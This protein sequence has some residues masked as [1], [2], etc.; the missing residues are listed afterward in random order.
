MQFSGQPV[1]RLPQSVRATAV[2]LRSFW[3]GLFG[4]RVA[5]LVD[6][7]RKQLFPQL[8]GQPRHQLWKRLT[9]TGLIVALMG[10]VWVIATIVV[11]LAAKQY[12][13]I[14]VFSI[15]KDS[16]VRLLET[17]TG[18]L[19]TL[20]GIGIP[21][22][23][24]V[25]ESVASRK[26]SYLLKQYL[27]K[28]GVVS[29]ALSGLGVLAGL[30]AARYI[31]AFY[32]LPS[33]SY[34]FIF[35]LMAFL[36]TLYVL[37]EIFRVISRLRSVFMP[38]FLED[39]LSGSLQK[40]INRQ[41]LNEVNSRLAEQFCNEVYSKHDIRH[42][43][44]IE[45]TGDYAPVYWHQSGQ[46]ID[47]N[48]TRFDFALGD[49]Q[50]ISPGRQQPRGLYTRRIFDRVQKGEVAF[51]L[52][53][54]KDVALELAQSILPAFRIAKRPGA[55]GYIQPLL[56]WLKERA[57]S[58][59]RDESEGEYERTIN[60]YCHM[61]S[62]SF[63]LP[64]LPA[65]GLR[66][67]FDL[68][69]WDL[70]FLVVFDLRNIAEAAARSPN[71]TFVRRLAW[72]LVFMMEQGV[73]SGRSEHLGDIPSVLELY[74][75]MFYSCLKSGHSPAARAVYDSL[76]DTFI[77]WFSFWEL[78][79]RQPTLEEFQRREKIYFLT[80]KTVAQMLRT[81]I[82]E[83]DIDNVHGLFQRLQLGELG[84][85]NIRVSR[86]N[87]NYLSEQ[88]LVANQ[89]GDHFDKFRNTLGD[90]L[91]DIHY[92]AA[93]YTIEGVNQET[94]NPADAEE[95]I[96]PYWNEQISL[97]NLV[98]L[99]ARNYSNRARTEFSVFNRRPD[100]RQVY[101]PDSEAKF[102]L[103]LIIRGIEL[104]HQKGLPS[105]IVSLD[106]KIALPQIQNAVTEVIV[107]WNGKWK[108]L[109]NINLST[110]KILAT[111]LVRYVSQCSDQ[112]EREREDEAIAAE[113]DTGKVAAFCGA[114][115]VWSRNLPLWQWLR[116]Y[117][118]LEHG[119]F[120]GGKSFDLYRLHNGSKKLFTF[121][122]S[123]N[124]PAEQLG[125]QWGRN[126]AAAQEN[127]IIQQLAA[128]CRKVRSRKTWP[129]VQDYFL[130]ACEELDAV[131]FS[132]SLFLLPDRINFRLLL[133]AA[134]FSPGHALFAGLDCAGCWLDIP[135]IEWRGFSNK[136][137]AIDVQKCMRVVEGD[138][139]C[140]ILSVDAAKRLV[141]HDIDKDCDDRVANLSVVPRVHQKLKVRLVD[142]RAAILMQMHATFLR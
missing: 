74:P 83:R 10:N 118:V 46:L 88:P 38:E 137:L 141:S 18:S 98:E 127:W 92:G 75:T 76:L 33:G 105:R 58:A 112:W 80:I 25:I 96:R 102:V 97:D 132:P 29:T 101:M 69:K 134:D 113:L 20:I 87:S 106:I 72:S 23:F 67:L 93:S 48:L 9:P 34:N 77:D 79:G 50:L 44:G 115:T 126:F 22:L 15:D 117:A 111:Q 62:L 13:A 84:L 47:M 89:F 124:N 95:L 27:D 55:T 26:A 122:H 21:V 63:Q 56:E 64:V 73:H 119:N 16:L 130:R 116:H 6:Q 138:L 40:E 140:E 59:I 53:A 51:Y 17:L 60:R 42:Y 39:V 85:D 35:S 52:S 65:E 133:A 99:F 49:Q 4:T 54:S 91:A 139:V 14:P 36:A 7:K 103:H 129:S 66:Q 61:L 37:I 68:G 24:L 5:R 110:A 94:I 78:K 12:L 125:Q 107:S 45:N 2:R 123:G 70:T 30:L 82:D 43:V 109:F 41:L 3:N 128:R 86:W 114:V 104:V 28:S 32:S 136:L 121:L 142:K 8:T 57:V 11:L 19:A 120:R 81:A 1:T 108:K 90:I 135:V 100:T 71:D 131:G 31:F